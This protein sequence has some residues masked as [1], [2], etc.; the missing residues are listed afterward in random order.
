MGSFK[1][2]PN[3]TILKEMDAG[4]SLFKFGCYETG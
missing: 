3:H 4:L 1:V 2:R